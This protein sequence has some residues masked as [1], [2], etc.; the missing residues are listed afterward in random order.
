MIPSTKQNPNLCLDRQLSAPTWRGQLRLIGSLLLFLGV[1][2]AL[3]ADAASARI[4]TA[5]WTYQQD[6]NGNGCHAGDLPGD[7]ARLNWSPVV[8]DCDGTLTVWEIVYAQDCSSSIW[9]TIY[10]NA[11][12]SI[13]GCRSIGD[14]YLDVAMGSNC[15]CRNY[16][17]EIYQV[18]STVPDDIHSGT[19][20]PNLAQH[21]EKLLS[22]DFCLS[23]YFDTC[24]SLSGPAG[25]YFDNNS[26]ATEEPGEPEHVPNCAGKSLWYCWTAPS[27]HSVT[28]DTLGST[29]DTVLA[30]YTGTVV[31]NLTLVA[32]NDDIAG[33][34]NRQ[35]RVTFTP[36]AEMTYHIAVDGYGDSSGNVLL[37]WNQTGA[38]LP[39]LTIWG[40]AASPTIITRDFSSNDCE[41]VEGCET[42]GLHTLLSFTTETRNVGTGDLIMGD[43]STN[44]L[45]YWATCHQHYHFEQFAE[46]NLLDQSNNII[47]TGHKVGFCLE[48]VHSWAPNANPQAK[49]DCT[50]QGIQAGWAD[51][52]QAGLP[53]Q[54]VDITGVAPGT[55]VLQMIVNPDNLIA[56]SDTLNNETR[57]E[58]VIPPAGC[59]SA[60]LNDDFSNALVITQSPF[61]YTEFNL[62]A[63]KEAGEPDHAGNSG[64][65]SVWFSWT[66]SSNQ[67]AVV[68]TRNSDFDTILA[69]YTGDAVDNL[70]VVAFNDD[71]VDGLYKQS[72]LSF[73]AQ[74]GTT[75]YIAV[76]GWNDGTTGGEVGTVVLNLN[77][78]DNDEFDSPQVLA[79][80]SGTIHGCNVAC[81]KETYPVQE[82]AHAGDVGGH[83]VWYSW[84]APEGGPVDFNTVGST[85]ST[86][87]AV[88]TGDSLGN[89]TQIAANIDDAEGSGL[90]SRVD[91]WA[92]KGTAYRIAIDG[93]GAAVGTFPLTW[94]MESRLSIDR[95]PGGQ[96][97]VNL[98]GVDWQ[99]YT[100]IES[101]NLENW[102][103]NTPAITMSGAIHHYVSDP[104][105]NGPGQKFYRAFRSN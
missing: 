32:S 64:G 92:V 49:Y 68:T 70:T 15:A 105:T 14:Q 84:T 4:S 53:C 99:R 66:P 44:A 8:V 60:P 12:H 42:V 27:S 86:T 74:A 85:F 87:M 34:T 40:P 71:I 56:E 1:L 11:P 103:T 17:I 80:T 100:L 91:F 101:E 9:T 63:T 61:S 83:S 96:T 82:R 45:F 5:W 79:G 72:Q 88:Y 78:A 47:A 21:K 18:G 25:S 93:F 95:L 52:Y 55:Y 33:W 3:A 28:F 19:S 6:C 75:Y 65:H 41:V 89:L 73:D 26:Y 104:G 31:S 90:A 62:C 43:P 36:V 29:F 10:T 46:Y 69:V 39:D 24:A 77:P 30:V 58:V 50:Y 2:S 38:A 37:N 13:T 102:S 98:T 94:N 67:T 57:V 35:S 97:R 51:V 59:V 81:S 54:Y 48:D 20:D 16:K 7:M 76:D 23:D 22:Q